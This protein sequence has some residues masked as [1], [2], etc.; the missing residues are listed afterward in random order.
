[1]SN[2][3]AKT[4]SAIADAKGVKEAMKV[5]L[6]SSKKMIQAGFI[7]NENTDK[8]ESGFPYLQYKY[9]RTLMNDFTFAMQIV[10]NMQYALQKNKV[11]AEGFIKRM[12][13]QGVSGT[14]YHLIHLNEKTGLLHRKYAVDARML[15][16]SLNDSNGFKG[17]L[18]IVYDE[19]NVKGFNTNNKTRND[20]VNDIIKKL[21]IKAKRMT[22]WITNG[23]D[24][25]RAILGVLKEANIIGQDQFDN[26][27][28]F[29]EELKKR[30]QEE[31]QE[32]S[33]EENQEKKQEEGLRDPS[34]PPLVRNPEAGAGVLSDGHLKFNITDFSGNPSYVAYKYT[35][36]QEKQKTA[37]LPFPKGDDK[38]SREIVRRIIMFAKSS[39]GKGTIAPITSMSEHVDV[40]PVSR[41]WKYLKGAKFDEE[42]DVVRTK[43]LNEL[44]T[45][46]ERTQP[47]VNQIVKTET[48][49][50]A[51]DSYYNDIENFALQQV[52]KLLKDE[53]N[54]LKDEN[55][56][57][58]KYVGKADDALNSY[59]LFDVELSEGDKK[60]R[61][62]LFTDTSDDEAL[63]RQYTELF[64][65]ESCSRTQYYEDGVD[66][67][68]NFIIAK[69]NSNA[70]YLKKLPFGVEHTIITGE[71]LKKTEERI[72]KEREDIE[73]QQKK[74]A[75]AQI[76]QE[77]SLELYDSDIQRILIDVMSMIYPGEM[78]SE[79]K[80]QDRVKRLVPK[81]MEL[82]NIGVSVKNSCGEYDPEWPGR[83][84]DL[85]QQEST[86]NEIEGHAIDIFKGLKGNDNKKIFNFL[87]LVGHN[88]SKNMSHDMSLGTVTK[89]TRGHSEG[90]DLNADEV[91]EILEKANTELDTYNKEYLTEQ[92][93]KLR[94]HVL[95]YYRK[96]HESEEKTE[97]LMRN[98][99][100]LLYTGKNGSQQT[101]YY[102]IFDRMITKY[103][104]LQKSMYKE[105]A[106]RRL[107]KS[108]AS[109]DTKIGQVKNLRL[110][111][112]NLMSILSDIALL[113]IDEK[114]SYGDEVY[115]VGE[116]L[117]KYFKD[118]QNDPYRDAFSKIWDKYTEIR[119]ESFKTTIDNAQEINW[120]G[121]RR[122]DNILVA[123]MAMVDILHYNGLLNWDLSHSGVP[124]EY[125]KS[126]RDN[127][128]NFSEFAEEFKKLY[129]GWKK[130]KEEANNHMSPEDAEW[131]E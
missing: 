120:S 77:K 49:E 117:K 34:T 114:I 35:D 98:Y 123:K 37:Y 20:I 89:V 1:M 59:R 58:K 51:I 36:Y 113:C 86:K 45:I 95:E 99:F 64:L 131:V 72:Q 17:L 15:S 48:K 116:K 7:Y 76:E 55:F 53:F 69:T 85:F 40:K 30:S 83:F 128:A 100:R 31:N 129:D 71:Q 41:L 87:Y 127:T 39:Y 97:T 62:Y 110:F 91:K 28:D 109:L 93:K 19:D 66:R 38:D 6:P 8:T 68:K 46:E 47:N 52:E 88:I 2:P 104:D 75:E 90:V 80:F 78:F 122:Q 70:D 126:Q 79:T 119:K 32:K 56:Y 63:S 26:A 105:Q 96:E 108:L 115:K 65:K 44:F 23:L 92:L 33:Q 57:F 81:F 102:S 16:E 118:A 4:F 84:W 25:A 10:A 130:L 61:V 13:K 82:E 124:D 9:T 14:I 121:G 3:R 60:G 74:L 106:K 50:D 5:A 27:E 12:S 24:V 125:L 21:Q 112:Q 42:V 22:N 94:K 111:E 11:E 73:E 43:G 18:G 101:S 54:E 103:N 107:E 29:W 67:L